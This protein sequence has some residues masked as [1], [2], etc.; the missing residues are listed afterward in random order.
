MPIAPLTPSS[1]VL[2]RFL[3]PREKYITAKAAS[4]TL[5]IKI[6]VVIIAQFSSAGPYISVLV[7]TA[8]AM[9]SVGFCRLSLPHARRA[10]ARAV[11]DD[12][13]PFTDGDILLLTYL[14]EGQEAV[15]LQVCQRQVLKL[16][17][18]RPT[19]SGVT[20]ARRY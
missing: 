19:S 4:N 12:K 11:L 8:R 13:H 6:K 14:M 5:T 15:V 3:R 10:Q 2:G 7:A 16:R 9:L 1:Y 17:S 18:E 20:S